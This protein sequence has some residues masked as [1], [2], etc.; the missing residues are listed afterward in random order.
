MRGNAGIV[1]V[2][3][4]LAAACASSKPAEQPAVSA[5]LPAP[6]PEPAQAQAPDA[7]PETVYALRFHPGPKW[8]AGQ[9]PFGQPGIG[10]HV[11]NLGAW[12]AAGKLMFGGPFLDS[13]GGMAVLRVAS[14][15]EAKK[16]AESDPCVVSGLMTT[17]IHPW[18]LAFTPEPEQ[19][20]AAAPAR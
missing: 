8:V 13:S 2:C 11:K 4:L 9:P 17:E 1:V 10:E 18:L 5:P 3:A 19:K 7:P 14:M 20:P 15:D 12:S 6:A 16:L